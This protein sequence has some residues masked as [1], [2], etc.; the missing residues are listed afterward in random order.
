MSRSP[1][2]KPPKVG[3]RLRRLRPWLAALLLVILLGYG[4]ARLLEQTVVPFALRKG[5]EFG[6]AQMALHFESAN[7]EVRI[8]R[9]IL[10]ENV[11]IGPLPGA[12]PGNLTRL[13]VSRIEIA[14][15]PLSELLFDRRRIVS[16]VLIKNLRGTLD[17]RSAQLP[18]FPPM[19]QLSEEE[20]L[21]ISQGMILGMPVS[22]QIRDSSLE[23]LADFQRYALEGIQGRLEE[24]EVHELTV[25]KISIV[26]GPARM[27]LTDRTARTAWKDG[28]VYLAS[29]ELVEGLTVENFSAQLAR[30]GGVGLSLE[31]DVFGGW[32]RSDFGFGERDEVLHMVASLWAGRIPLDQLSEALA[33]PF[34]LQGTLAETFITFRGFPDRMAEGDTRL[35]LSADDFL[36]EKRGW[37]QLRVAGHLN[38]R[39]I[40]LEHFEL[41]QDDNIIRASGQFNLPENTPI[42]EADF[43]LQADAKIKDLA[44]LAALG[45]EA[46]E[47]TQG[48]LSV[49]ADLSQQG[50]ER[51]GKVEASASDLVF[52][53]L[54]LGSLKTVLRVGRDELVVETLEQLSGK[55]TL[56]LKGNVQLS[57]PHRYSAELSLR[58]ADLSPYAAVLLPGEEWSGASGGLDLAWQGD[59]MATAHSGA[60]QLSLHKLESHR[61]PVGLNAAATGTY[62]P[63]SIYL[64]QLSLKQGFFA[65]GATLW[66]GANGV[67]IQS[68][69]LEARGRKVADGE[70]Y[71]PWDP[72]S[73]TREEG[74]QSGVLEDKKLY[75]QIRSQSLPLGEIFALA[76]QEAP[77]TGNVSFQLDA[78]GE[79]IDPTIKASLTTG[80]IRLPKP[81]DTLLTSSLEMNLVS[82]A[83]RAAVDATL[84]AP[85]VEPITM[86]AAFPLGFVKN[87][88]GTLQLADPDGEFTGRINLPRTNLSNFQPLAGPAI[89]SLTGTLEGEIR[90]SNR[91]SDLQIDGRLEVR[92]GQVEFPG[93]APSIDNLDSEV[94]FTG[95]EIRL[96]RLDGTVGAGPFQ[97]KGRIGLAD[98]SQPEYDFTLT[99]D[100]VLIFRDPGLRLRANLDLRAKGQGS[101]GEVTGTIRL[102][103]GRIYRRLEITPLIASAGIDESPP[104]LLPS[105]SG[106]VPEPFA[107]WSMKVGISNAT[108]FQL[109]GNIASG[110]I[111][112]ALTV[113]G[114]L[115]DPRPTGSI[116]LR[117]IR[118]YLPFTV[119]DIPEGFIYLQE[120][121][122][123]VPLL[124]IRAFAQALE[125]EIQA[126]AYGPLDQRNFILRS[127]PPL[128]QD[129]IILLM[130]TGLAPGVRAGSG[131]GQAAIGQGS[132]LLLKTFA[133]QFEPEGVDTDSLINR[134][135]IRSVPPSIQGDRAGLQG[136]F[137]ITDRFSVIA[138]R[139]SSGYYNAGFTYRIRFR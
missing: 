139:D 135:N 68:L 9:P 95:R 18:E 138:E 50:T 56:V 45:G 17:F 13:D 49:V 53:G 88:D 74:W 5:L 10:I 46:F 36:W 111:D 27:E 110:D 85:R 78:S 106:F 137:R 134:L 51:N 107:S 104:P 127:D 62:S 101:A 105:M 109:V 31:A 38:H 23:I 11:V 40:R 20:Q 70:L 44:A 22:V 24:S 132:M 7:I 86:E 102:V 79:L 121:N 55:D 69:I 113:G 6:I 125:Y 72:R 83:G 26:A 99:G 21:R 8:G 12:P 73:L 118:A 33:L 117:D 114:K 61:F 29:M 103:D 16:R 60:F 115:G 41:E 90:L 87:D 34:A 94:V 58:V 97:A 131:F 25:D 28:T 42:W 126:V 57:E 76:G 82:E 14:I 92:G 64:S 39:A 71:L 15:R 122:P 43:S 116:G 32:L 63:D 89:S 136:E 2:T 52:R 47:Q 65:L 108:P 98:F 3:G 35:R 54:P 19:P 93:A 130:T 37:K 120:D 66:A 4:V 91:L 100:K 84:H 80:E 59:G 77:V 67:S 133:R 112:P 123:R 119:M 75:A 128:P 129:E 48:T 30:P 1:T 81:E 124:D 96:A